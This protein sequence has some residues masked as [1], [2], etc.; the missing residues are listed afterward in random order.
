MRVEAENVIPS[1]FTDPDVQTTGLDPSRIVD[2]LD[3]RVPRR[4]VLYQ[5]ARAVGRA[6]VNHEHLDLHARG[7]RKRFDGLETRDDEVAFLIAR[8]DDRDEDRSRTRWERRRLE[9]DG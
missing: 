6:A 8:N 2:Q 4:D 3:T 5:V 9:L 1:G 7:Q